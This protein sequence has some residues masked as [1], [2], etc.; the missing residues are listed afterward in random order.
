MKVDE[1]LRCRFLVYCK[2]SF[3]FVENFM[4]IISL[5]DVYSGSFVTEKTA[6][7]LHKIRVLGCS[8]CFVNFLD[9]SFFLNIM[10]SY[11]FERI[12]SN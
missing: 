10:S 12:F 6:L 11:L 1:N 4:K 5:K 3:R 2:R 9:F 8:T 7:H